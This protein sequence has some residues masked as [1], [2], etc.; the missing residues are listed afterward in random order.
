LLASLIASGFSYLLAYTEDPNA[1]K[2]FKI[3]LLA[4][5]LTLF[6][7]SIWHLVRCPWLVHKMIL[8]RESNERGIFGMLGLIAIVAMLSAGYT[9]IGYLWKIRNIPLVMNLK[10]IPP[11]VFFA[12]THIRPVINYVSSTRPNEANGLFP[13]ITTVNAEVLRPLNNPQILLRCGH[14]CR[15][16]GAATRGNEN[17]PPQQLDPKQL[18]ENEIRIVFGEPLRPNQVFVFQIVQIANEPIVDLSVVK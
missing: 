18:S 4:T 11:P 2:N 16:S 1:W 6:A 9:G 10:P 3:V 14:S 8:Q 5:G 15:W 17:R 7:F 12:P 13:W